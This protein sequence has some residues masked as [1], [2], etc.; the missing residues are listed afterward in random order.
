MLDSNEGKLIS[1]LCIMDF[2]L[3]II[4]PMCRLCWLA[5]FAFINLV[6]KCF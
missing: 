5:N 4:V 6:E 3:D 2:Y 1:Y